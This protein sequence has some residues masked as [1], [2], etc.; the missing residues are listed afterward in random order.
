M[1][2]MR[3]L[4]LVLLLVIAAAAPLGAASSS[5]TPLPDH[6]EE[7]CDWD[8]TYHDTLAMLG[9]DERDWVVWGGSSM[10]GYY[11]RVYPDTGIPV[12]HPDMPCSYVETVIVHEWLHLQQL[13]H[14]G[15][16]E[17]TTH[18]AGGR[19]NA[20]MVAECGTGLIV[21]DPAISPHSYVAKSRRT[22]GHG[23][24]PWHLFEASRLIADSAVPTIALTHGLTGDYVF[25]PGKGVEKAS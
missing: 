12:I 24:T 18:A 6:T 14:Y 17:A 20:E 22:R 5:A 16:W 4:A 1:I 3:T 13:D 2:A 7:P 23:C 25:Y 10:D 15:S 21:A 8:Y 9:E 11:G 19:L